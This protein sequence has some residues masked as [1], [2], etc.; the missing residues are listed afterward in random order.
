[1]SK[2]VT[3]LVTME[4]L[5]DAIFGSG[6]SVPGGEDIAVNT[7]VRGLPCLRGST[8]KGL[9]R[10]SLENL[11]CWT[12][13]EESELLSLMGGSG[14][15]GTDDGRRICLTELAL[16]DDGLTPEDCYS[17]RAFTALEG[18]TAK[19]GTLRLARCVR[20]GLRFSG[21]LECAEEDEALLRDALRGVKWVGTM[22][23]RGFGRVRCSCRRAEAEG[24]GPA[25]VSG[26]ACLRYR[27]RTQS[28]VLITDLSRSSSSSYETRSL[29]PGSAVRGMVMSALAQREPEWFEAHRRELLGEGTRFLDA[30]PAGEAPVI[31]S[32]RGFYEDKE[33]SVFVSVLRDGEVPAGL[34][35]AKLGHFC[36]LRGDTVLWQSPATG[37]ATRIDRGRGGERQMFQTRSIDAGQEFEGYV[38]LTRPELSEK[39]SGC[40]RGDVWLGADR[41]A[42]FGKCAVTALEA[43][44][45]PRWLEYSYGEGETPGETLYMLA[46]SPFTMRDAWGDHCGLDQDRLAE[47]LGV[48]RAEVALCSA[49]VSEY[50]G[51]NR[52]WG[53]RESALPMYDRGSLFKLRCSS[54]PAREALEKLTAEGLGVRRAEGFGQV[55]FLRPALYEGLRRKEK[56]GGGKAGE[57]AAE[58]AALRRA[59]YRWVMD[60]AARIRGSK[61]SASQIG[62][63]QARCEKALASGDTG[64]L[65]RFCDKNLLERGAKQGERFADTAAFVRGVLEKPLAD[66][67]G[68]P[69][70]DSREEKLHLLI[71]LFDFSRKE[72]EEK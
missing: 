3:L 57:A 7:D 1:M 28:P 12:G 59:R 5:S 24:R 46:L 31:P 35:R 58:K 9:V 44:P 17:D 29:I 52:T 36:A 21:Q 56:A 65:E 32:P 38:L 37:G 54:P 4:L 41:Y 64:E 68:L 42:G 51:Y 70:P 55:L 25:P 11:L 22:R 8:F 34:K 14:W 23:S 66:T 40:L 18:G 45:R 26:A 69:C 27:L 60:N 16:T 50:G 62:S 53:C 48:E 20:G 72:A 61:L 10:E 2:R 47:K 39:L 33:E 67:L 30:L 13:G 71:L 15:N 63:L 6:H 19:A 49:S 43:S